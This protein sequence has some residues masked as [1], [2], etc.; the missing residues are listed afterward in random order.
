MEKLPELVSKLWTCRSIHDRRSTKFATELPYR[1]FQG[2]L[3]ETFEF[4]HFLPPAKNSW[5]CTFL[6]FFRE[7]KSKSK[8]PPADK[9]SPQT[10][11][12]P[13]RNWFSFKGSEIKVSPDVA[14]T[15]S[16]HDHLKD[17]WTGCI[18]YKILTYRMQR[19]VHK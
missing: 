10:E 4:V 3:E 7:Y 9:G 12:A 1:L 15:F 11:K 16:D 13:I 17:G 8:K 2:S 19:T 18:Y 6:P 5:I 14:S